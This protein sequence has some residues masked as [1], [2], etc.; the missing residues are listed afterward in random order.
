[1]AGQMPEKNI[2]KSNVLITSKY[3]G[4][5]LENKIVT[6]ALSQVK[7]AEL[8]DKAAE[9][10]FTA[11]E[12]RRV[13]G[14][15]SGSFYSKL[16]PVAQA[17]GGRVIGYEDPEKGEFEYIPLIQ[18]ARY[19]NGE[20][21]IIFNSELKKY[22]SDITSNF[23]RLNLQTMMNFRSD[24][25]FR[26]YELLK[27]Y[28]YHPKG[29]TATGELY[30]IRYGIAELKFVI[31]VVDA[32]DPAAKS[33]LSKISKPTNKDY[34]AAVLKAKRDTAYDDWTALRRRVIDPAVKEICE[35]TEMIVQYD[36]ERSG[37]GG[38]VENILFTM[39]VVQPVK[40]APKSGEVTEE[41]KENV[42][43]VV[44][45]LMNESGLAMKLKDV[46]N[47]AEK[48]KYN[49]YLIRKAF[50]LY[51]TSKE[52]VEDPIAYIL[53]AIERNFIP[54]KAQ[55]AAA[56]DRGIIQIGDQPVEVDFTQMSL[57][58]EVPDDAE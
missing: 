26:L 48:S 2:I 35:K 22:I 36:T 30:S 4:T 24:Y 40:S 15:N 17:L 6:Y 39:Q 41:E 38:K 14:S 25:T 29:S 43:D 19:E 21:T 34:A 51:E 33:Y 46:A 44:L 54:T 5:L 31:G 42:M 16:I 37:R 10:T 7:E 13:T 12:L 9:Y 49:V 50:M 57:P 58:F 32:N 20:F 28:C 1:M 23:T 8:G 47:I 53:A 3:K 52:K 11:A 56:K 45:Q 55:L 18:K 27:S